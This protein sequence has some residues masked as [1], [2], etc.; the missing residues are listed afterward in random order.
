MRLYKYI[1]KSLQQIFVWGSE[2]LKNNL[3][4]IITYVISIGLSLIF[5]KPLSKLILTFGGQINYQT[6]S[7]QIGFFSILF[8]IIV[9]YIKFI[10]R[11]FIH[12]K[13]TSFLIFY[14]S[15]FYFFIRFIFIEHIIFLSHKNLFVYAD[16]I[17]IIGLLHFLNIVKVWVKDYIRIDNKTKSE[18]KNKLT[19]VS[20]S[21][22][23]EDKIYK[24]NQIDNEAILQ[25]LIKTVSGFKPEEAFSIGM[26]A[27][28]GYGKSSFLHRFKS[29]YKLKQPKEIVFW[30]RIWKNKG[31]TAIIENFFDELKHQLIPFSSEI[32]DD[33]GNYVDSILSLSNGELTKLINSGKELLSEN[34]TLENYYTSINNSIKKIDKQIIILLDDLDRLEK[35]EIINTLKLIRTLSDFANIIF[36]AGY[37]RKYIIDSISKPKDNYLDKIFNVEIN[38]INFDPKLIIDELFMHVNNTYPKKESDKDV[39]NFNDSFKNLFVDKKTTISDKSIESLHGE[40]N[41]SSSYKLN[42]SS[43]FSTYRDVKRFINEFKFNASFF[44]YENDIIP[45]EYIL[46]KL[47][48]YKYRFIDQLVL[49]KIDV[50]LKRYNISN[51]GSKTT[52][53]GT[54]HLSDIYIYDSEV[55]E[56]IKLVVNCGDDDFEIIN[57]VFCRLFGKKS[58]EFY[59]TKQNSISKIYYTDLYI[60]NNLV[61]KNIY[62]SQLQKAFNENNLFDLTETARKESKNSSFHLHNEIKQFI[63]NVKPLSKLHYVDI[64]KTLNRI[65]LNN[66]INDNQNVLNI[67]NNAFLEFYNGNRKDFILEHSELI[68]NE[69]FNYLDLLFSEL[70]INSK[71]LLN[72]SIYHG[73]ENYENS[74][75]SDND[76]REIYL[77]KLTY[78]IDKN[79]PPEIIFSTYNSHVEAIVYDKRIVMS[80]EANTLIKEDLTARFSEYYNSSTFTTIKGGISEREGEFVGY[81]PNFNLASIF[82]NNETHTTLLEDKDNKDLYSQFYKEGW[83]NFRDYL[84]KI[85]YFDGSLMNVNVDDF[86]DSKKFIANFIENDCKPLNKSNYDKIF[87]KLPA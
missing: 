11:A 81:A 34:E 25:E 62:I 36:I 58:I 76:I 68:N 14:I 60:R 65:I 26:N 56:K 73:L 59:K 23:I 64:L 27:V 38:L 78:L 74:F 22:F 79:A 4:F 12:N 69:K 77:N 70:N 6:A 32:S 20:S 30:Y 8:L 21:F 85:N 39:N 87:K 3:K 66:S 2:F 19:G 53:F 43:F 18:V 47:L 84:E 7:F 41:Y 72:P 17:L 35:D 49:S 57:S 52:Y 80:T 71:R 63:F 48:S 86:E 61:S 44:K 5:I 13:R 51:S 28:W 37:D 45:E 82:S 75:L 42:Y 67:M 1:L 29:Q 31:S 55:K 24:N 16:W 54:D 46:L 10:S 40:K 83:N 9:L 50:F 15:I 33:I